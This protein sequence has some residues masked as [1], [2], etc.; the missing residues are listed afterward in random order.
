MKSDSQFE[1]EWQE[2][3]D[4]ALTDLTRQLSQASLA[5]PM[6]PPNLASQLRSSHVGWAWSTDPS[7][8]S[9]SVY[10]IFGEV[11][12]SPLQQC[13][14]PDQSDFWMFG[15]RGYGVNSYG[16]GVVSRVGPLFVAH[17]HGWGG[18]YMRETASESVDAATQS[19][20]ETLSSLGSEDLR[21]LHVAVLFS[22]YRRY[23]MLW[24]RDE[25]QSE[26]L[27]NSY[28]IPGWSCL[29]SREDDEFQT[30]FDLH[31][32]DDLAIAIG[33]GHLTSLLAGRER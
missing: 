4:S 7:I 23:A 16:I 29:W 5:V 31:F 10:S 28:V 9:W 12:P 15:H 21:D 24:V 20:N 14:H 8:N 26:D 32:V 27:T 22:S 2:P 18:A 33:A 1:S 13:L 6:V 30:L 19:W 25:S 11:E 3:D 17:Q